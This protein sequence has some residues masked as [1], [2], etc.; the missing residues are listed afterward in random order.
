MVAALDPE[1][2]ETVRTLSPPAFAELCDSLAADDESTDAVL[3][4]RCRTDR[5]LFCRLFLE[6]RFP[7]DWNRMHLDFLAR[8]KTSFDAREAPAKI[9]DAAPRGGAKSTLES[10]AEPVHDVCYGLEAFIGLTST[11]FGLSE[12]LVKDLHQTF[13]DAEAHADLHRVFGPFTLRGT[14]TDF[15]VT[16]PGGVAVGTRIKAF[17][18]GGT[19]RGVKHAGIRPT[20]WIIDDGEHPERVRSPDQR[21]KT[22]DFL[23]KDILKSGSRCT[24]YRV[25]GTVLHPDSMLANLLKSPGW[26]AVRWR[27]VLAWPERMDLWEDCRRLWARLE[28]P[29]R[30]ATARAFYDAHRDEM[31][32]GAEV[33]WP[34]NEPLWALM[35]LLWADGV[36][37]FYSEKQNEPRDPERQVFDTDRFQRFRFDG[38]HIHMPAREVGGKAIPG[39]VVPLADCEI[40]HWLDPS[41]GK[42][43]SD[44][45]ALATVACERRTGYRFVLR[46]TLDKGP[47]DTQRARVWAEFEHL[48]RGKWGTDETGL[49]ALFGEG[50]ERE[51]A[52]RKQQGRAWQLPMEGHKLSSDKIVRISR[53]Q[54]D[55][56]NGFIQFAD[57][58]PLAVIEQFRDF[59]TAAHDDAP[60]AIERADWLLSN[61]SMPT[62]T[63]TTRGYR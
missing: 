59:P 50:F 34:E 54:P 52:E 63:P 23:T 37:S 2:T 57:D 53:L 22:W 40:A 5:A 35:L 47:P 56:I 29:D 31:D 61:E 33:L 7:L 18:F 55:A 12:D 42:A 41:L 39:R 49:G 15:V 26:R 11:T 28:D 20:K 17:S 32:R 13:K 27:A 60:D 58:L 14:E 21:A 36:A 45:P 24:I 38:T 1:A 62:I 51:K 3:F 19:V 10:Y 9:A 46:C 8:P 6:G 4:A 16:C 25:V 30:E 44:F 48:P 43:T